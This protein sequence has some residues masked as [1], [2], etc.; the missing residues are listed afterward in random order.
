[1][2]FNRILSITGAISPIEID[3]SIQKSQEM[4]QA[5]PTS[6]GGVGGNEMEDLPTKETV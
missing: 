4:S 1:M 5:L 6:N 3:Q 2:L